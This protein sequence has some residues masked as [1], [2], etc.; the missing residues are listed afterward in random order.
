MLVENFW[1]AAIEDGVTPAPDSNNGS[2]VGL[3]YLL[4]TLDPDTETRS[5]A[6]SAHYDRVIATRPNYHLLP[7]QQ[8]SKV[9]FEGKKAVGVEFITRATGNVSRVFAK[10]E[11]ILSAG[12]THTPQILQLSGVGPRGLLEGF[13]IDVVA[14]LPGVGANFHDQH[15]YNIAYNLSNNIEPNANTLATNATF[16][17]EQ[18]EVYENNHTG[19][20]TV[21]L[22]A[23]NLFASLPLSNST[24]TDTV[25]AM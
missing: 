18:L 9:V 15:K 16:A 5:Y 17:A 2:P 10:K 22:G 6:R 20:Y 19:A 1:D 23:G 14:E 24:D 21:T 12:S 7:E 13:G 25:A 4:R 3:F 8:V 11:V